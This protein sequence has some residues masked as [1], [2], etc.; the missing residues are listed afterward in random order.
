[1]SYA[2][3]FVLACFGIADAATEKSMHSLALFTIPKMKERQ[4]E[5]A[6]HCA[7]HAAAVVIPV[8]WDIGL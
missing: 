8:G 4:A 2:T 5:L 6:L 3:R 7:R 1:L